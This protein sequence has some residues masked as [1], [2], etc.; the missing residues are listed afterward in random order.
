MSRALEPI[1]IQQQQSLKVR[2][3]LSFLKSRSDWVNFFQRPSQLWI[4]CVYADWCGGC[5]GYTPELVRI[6]TLAKWPQSKISIGLIETDNLAT[7]WP[8]AP[9]FRYFPAVFLLNAK[10]QSAMQGNASGLQNQ[11]NVRAEV[12]LERCLTLLP[13]LSAAAAAAPAPS[14]QGSAVLLYNPK[15]MHRQTV[16]FA[17]NNA[18]ILN[19]RGTMNIQLQPQAD[20]VFSPQ[21][22]YNNERLMGPDANA[23]LSKWVQGQ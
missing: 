8:N 3:E 22:V 17:V 15:T 20:L 2:T 21:L 4:V 19:E 7:V 18:K 12:L 13:T 11:P 16:L 10:Q 23:L 9:G 1:L 5:H 6:Q 14:K